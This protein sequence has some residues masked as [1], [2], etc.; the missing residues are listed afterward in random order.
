MKETFYFS[1]DYHARSDPK[2]VKLIQKRWWEGYWIYWWIIE[3]LYE[4]E[5]SIEKDYELLAYEFRTTEDIIESI[6]TQFSLFSIT[7][8]FIES[9][10][11]ND[12]LAKRIEKSEKAKNN[13]MERWGKKE[14]RKIAENTIFY[15][16]RIYDDNED[17]I[18]CWITTESISRRYSFFLNYGTLL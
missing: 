4:A 9:K 11:V 2:I 8:E 3:K 13:A 6:V 5:W 15:V 17:F 18:K 16:I 14:E 10:S 1:H 12:R 7:D